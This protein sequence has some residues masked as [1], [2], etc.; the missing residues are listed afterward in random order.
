MSYLP[1]G[2]TILRENAVKMSV[3]N[4]LAGSCNVEI[5]SYGAEDRSDQN[6]GYI[7][8]NGRRAFNASWSGIHGSNYR[9]I[10]TMILDPVACLAVD[11]H[12]WDVLGYASAAGDLVAYINYLRDGAILLAATADEASFNLQPAV[13]TLTTAG[14]PLSATSSYTEINYRGKYA[15]VLQKGYPEK[16]VMAMASRGADSLKIKVHL[17]G[18]SIECDICSIS[19]SG[20]H[21]RHA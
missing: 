9:G 10:N 1:A 3:T 12:Q 13:Q 6:F 20:Q 5:Q 11:W 18:E 16:T 15:F 7:E 17:K 14:V 19:Y 2:E 4:V 21:H 8:V